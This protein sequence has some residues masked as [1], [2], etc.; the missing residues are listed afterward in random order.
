M[1]PDDMF[2]FFSS[3]STLTKA[4]LHA[5]CCVFLLLFPIPSFTCSALRSFSCCSIAKYTQLVVIYRFLY[6]YIPIS[7][8]HRRF[9]CFAMFRVAH[10]FCVCVCGCCFRNA[11]WKQFHM[12][13]SAI[14]DVHH[15]LFYY[16]CSTL[17]R[18]CSLALRRFR[19]ILLVTAADIC[20]FF[21]S[22][23]ATE[24]LSLVLV[25]AVHFIVFCCV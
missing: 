5:S 24:W 20:S 3:N 14:D 17:F 2:L 10:L 1:P 18:Y 11:Q 6:L 19:S 23:T 4:T 15:Y 8:A 25:L 22:L 16:S 7:S 9:H 12:P 21:H 13:Q